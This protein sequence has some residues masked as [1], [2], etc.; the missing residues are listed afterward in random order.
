MKCKNPYCRA[1]N[2]IPVVEIDKNIAIGLKCDCCGA[3]YS[4]DEIEVI[5]TVKRE[6]GGWN[7]VKWVLK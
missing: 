6:G 3:R 1:S 2:F 4:I 5:K 7:S